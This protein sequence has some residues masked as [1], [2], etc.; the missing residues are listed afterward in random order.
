MP[1]FSELFRSY[2]SDADYQTA[3][4]QIIERAENG[5]LLSAPSSAT[6]FPIFC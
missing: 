2:S 4:D 5:P 1:T 6:S 3:L